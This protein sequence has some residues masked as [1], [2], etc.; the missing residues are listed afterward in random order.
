MLVDLGADPYMIDKVIAG[1]GMPMGPFR[2]ASHPHTR[3]CHYN[4]GPQPSHMVHRF[5]SSPVWRPVQ[6]HSNQACMSH[7]GACFSVGSTR[8]LLH[9]ECK[10]AY[11]PVACILSEAKILALPTVCAG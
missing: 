5:C 3:L 10:N 6:W 9:S 7:S 2:C 1:F 8:G 4:T 11:E